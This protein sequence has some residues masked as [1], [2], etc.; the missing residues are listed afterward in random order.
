M[1][2]RHALKSALVLVRHLLHGLLQRG[3]LV[4]QR[5]DGRGE[6]LHLQ[7]L[8]LHRAVVRLDARA[9]S[10]LLGR[11]LAQLDAQVLE[12]G[13]VARVQVGLALPLR[14]ALP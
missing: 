9:Q 14:N 1:V 3:D 12:L 4:L 8:V 13:R 6:L 2:P 5:R 10:G 7:L 11:A